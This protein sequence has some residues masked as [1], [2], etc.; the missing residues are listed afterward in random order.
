M[1][2]AEDQHRV[3][4]LRPGGE[5]EPFRVSVHAR[6]SGRDLHGLD[7]SVGQDCVERLGELPGPVPDQEPEARG[8]ITQIHQQVADLLDSPRA[9]R[10]RCDPEDVH[11]AAADLDD[12][13]AVQA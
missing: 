4:D 11:V 5:H 8:A 2:L 7:T 12:E 10:V 9:V 1:S 6:T 3:G 13:Q